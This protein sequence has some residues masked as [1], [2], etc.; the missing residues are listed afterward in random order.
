[1]MGQGSYPPNP[2]PVPCPLIVTGAEGERALLGHSLEG[3]EKEWK[4]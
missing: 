1:M 2:H 4:N 3:G